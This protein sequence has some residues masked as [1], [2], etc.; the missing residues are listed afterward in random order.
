MNNEF[1]EIYDELSK[2]YSNDTI[3]RLLLNERAANQRYW[4]NILK[5]VVDS[6][7]KYN[8][9]FEAINGVL[10]TMKDEIDRYESP[11]KT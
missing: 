3:N 7:M 2:L 11:R 1:I 10:S 6:P 5:K 8:K 4:Y 9:K